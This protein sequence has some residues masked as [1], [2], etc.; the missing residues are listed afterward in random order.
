VP[1]PVTNGPDYCE[2]GRGIPLTSAL[3]RTTQDPTTYAL[4]INANL[5]H[6]GQQL[7]GTVHHQA[8]HTATDKTVICCNVMRKFSE[9][10][11]LQFMGHQDAG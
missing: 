4:I 1:P 11:A 8:R 9:A 2:L 3:S 7:H 10:Q 6:L 5:Q